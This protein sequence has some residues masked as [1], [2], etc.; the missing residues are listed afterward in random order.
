MQHATKPNPKPQQ[1]QERRLR[2]RPLEEP[3]NRV[4]TGF[5][6]SHHSTMKMVG[7]RL[8]SKQIE[9]A[10]GMREIGEQDVKGL[11]GE[12]CGNN[13][14]VVRE[15][16]SLGVSVGTRTLE[17]G[18]KAMDAVVV[19]QTTDST[20]LNAIAQSS[21]SSSAETLKVCRTTESMMIEGNRITVHYYALSLNFDK[22]G[23]NT[24]AQLTVLR[25]MVRTVRAIQRSNEPGAIDRLA[26]ATMQTNQR[27]HHNPAMGFLRSGCTPGIVAHDALSNIAAVAEANLTGK[28]L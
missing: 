11:F 10:T 25:D 23:R 18:R 17:Y 16:Q 13:L 3:Y 9:M 21:A 1:T 26:Q 27:R 2:A 20:V 5:Y 4:L 15:A 19:I 14:R 12:D 7:E 6:L 22:M 24:T 8:K 28:K